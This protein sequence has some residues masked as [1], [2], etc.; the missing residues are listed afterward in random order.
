MD[1]C[2]SL[3]GF[4]LDFGCQ[5][6]PGYRHRTSRADAGLV[7][8]NGGACCRRRALRCAATSLR[9]QRSMAQPRQRDEYVGP[10]VERRELLEAHRSGGNMA[11]DVVVFGRE[12]ILGAGIGIGWSSDF[13]GF[14]RNE[15]FSTCIEYCWRCSYVTT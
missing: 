15:I 9:T 1:G 2:L 11:P 4:Q 8:G 7:A 12:R 5:S 10:V 14:S 6:N 13:H 3:A